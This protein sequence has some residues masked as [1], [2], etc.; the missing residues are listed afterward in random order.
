MTRHDI[1]HDFL[2]NLSKYV[3]YIRYRNRVTVGMKWILFDDMYL[4]NHM[5]EKIR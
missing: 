4:L 3:C 2:K 5:N 1:C